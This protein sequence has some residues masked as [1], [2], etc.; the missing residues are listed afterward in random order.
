MSIGQ[1]YM[2]MV[3]TCLDTSAGIFW[4]LTQ[5]S[6]AGLHSI[7]QADVDWMLQPIPV[8]LSTWMMVEGAPARS[9]VQDTVQIACLPDRSPIH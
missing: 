4:I 2:P 8:S 1:G 6:V 9:G 5:Y 7:Q 3:E